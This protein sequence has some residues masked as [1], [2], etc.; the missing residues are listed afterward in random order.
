MS[1]LD[2]IIYK[3]IR[4]YLDDS[5]WETVFGEHAWPVEKVAEETGYS[6]HYLYKLNVTGEIEPI[7]VGRKRFLR[8]SEV[9]KLFLKIK[10]IP[11]DILPKV[12]C[13]KK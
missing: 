8:R 7:K 11:L 13:P 5:E 2:T 9:E 1:E 6:V 3:N 4:A 12:R 10:N